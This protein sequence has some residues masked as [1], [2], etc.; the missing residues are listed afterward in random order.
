VPLTSNLK[1]PFPSEFI[2]NSSK[3]NGLKENSRFL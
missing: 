3:E 1:K 2:I